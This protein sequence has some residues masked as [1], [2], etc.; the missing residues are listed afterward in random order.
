MILAGELRVRD[1]GCDLAR[2]LR[3]RCSSPSGAVSSSVKLGMGRSESRLKDKVSAGPR[4][5]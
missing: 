4:A 1:H 2:G 5:L 3:G